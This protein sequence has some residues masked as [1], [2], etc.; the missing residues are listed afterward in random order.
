[1]SNNGEVTD[2]V[3]WELPNDPLGAFC[4]DNHIS[5]QPTGSG[6]LDG[7][8][9]AAKD[10]MDIIGAKTG[11]GQPTW[12]RTHDVATENALVVDRLLAAGAELVGKT[13]TDE[14]SYSLSG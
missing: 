13:V 8:K 5:L 1:M 4:R 2:S 9:F 7:L 14:L 6:Q 10:V 12:L 11:F 3:D